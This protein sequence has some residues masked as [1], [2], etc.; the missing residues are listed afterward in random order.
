MQL[1]RANRLN[2]AAAA[3]KQA[4]QLD[5]RYF[6]AHYN[7]GLVTYLS[8][9]YR[10]SLTAWESAL[11]IRPDSTD[12]RYNFA[13]TLKAANRPR[14]AAGELEKVLTTN[15]NEARAHLVLGNLYAET[16]QDRAKARIHYL[17]VLELDPRHP[18]AT[19]IRYW[20]VAHPR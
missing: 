4:T 14:D 10:Q 19:A 15:P 16:L 13:L 1:Q 11:A 9:S 18:Q 20:L 2:E 6:E 12:A 8:R 17:K 7:L 5:A 3:Y